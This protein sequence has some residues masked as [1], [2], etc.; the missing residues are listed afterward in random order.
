MYYH[1]VKTIK[2]P[3]KKTYWAI[4]YRTDRPVTYVD[5]CVLSGYIGSI[6]KFTQC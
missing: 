6:P 2:N 5:G 4:C 1:I 3:K